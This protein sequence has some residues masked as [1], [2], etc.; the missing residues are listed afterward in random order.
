MRGK[1]TL[2]ASL[3]FAVSMAA[4]TGSAAAAIPQPAA[5]SQPKHRRASNGP[6]TKAHQRV[7]R[8]SRN[9]QRNR[10]AHRG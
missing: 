4:A 2:L 10:K 8:K 1:S 6:G 3:G 9:V 5:V 7:A